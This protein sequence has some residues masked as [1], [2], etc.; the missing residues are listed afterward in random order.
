MDIRAKKQKTI[1]TAMASGNN[2]TAAEADTATDGT[3][4]V[5]RI[6]SNTTNTSSDLDSSCSARA[7]NI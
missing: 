7:N 6:I 4:A 2:A 3:N 1:A 5:P